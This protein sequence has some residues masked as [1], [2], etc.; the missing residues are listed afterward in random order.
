M[1][2][3]LF[4]DLLQRLQRREGGARAAP[5]SISASLSRDLLHSQ[6]P[7]ALLAIAG[8]AR[9]GNKAFTYAS[10]TISSASASLPRMP[11]AIRNS[12]RL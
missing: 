12:V 7:Q 5:V 4:G 2:A 10:C 11:R 6:A 1:A 3:S 9:A 8:T